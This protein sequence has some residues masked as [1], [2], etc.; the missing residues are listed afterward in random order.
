MSRRRSF[1][2]HTVAAGLLIAGSAVA[3]ERSASRPSREAQ[4]DCVWEKLSD[5]AVGLEAWVQRCD[6]GF[7][8]IHFL[9]ADGALQ[10]RYSDSEGPLDRVVEVLDLLG[11]EAP[12]AGIRRLFDARTEKSL[13]SRCVL[14]P[15]A[16][17]EPAPAGVRRLNMVPDAAY[18]RELARQAD[19]NEIGD[20]PCGEWGDVMDGIQYFEAHPE[21]GVRKVL[22]VR[23]GQDTPLFDEQTLRLVTPP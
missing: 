11:G 7:R 19:P 14:A 21:S 18:A 12:E 8:K 17:E 2:A 15:Y 3:G 16:T 1:P 20:P 23:V 5:A 6:F 13:A 4:E 22:F 10:V 9:L